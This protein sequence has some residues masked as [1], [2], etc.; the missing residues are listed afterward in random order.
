MHIGPQMAD[1]ISVDNRK[2]VIILT[3][4]Q[5]G[6]PRKNI[7]QVTKTS[8]YTIGQSNDRFCCCVVHKTVY[9]AVK[10]SHRVD[11]VVDWSVS[12]TQ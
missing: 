12:F 9:L 11:L 5:K 1:N 3:L 7:S 2:R 4:E 6:T 10:P 8:I